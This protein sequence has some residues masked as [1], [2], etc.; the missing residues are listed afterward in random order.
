M[1]KTV[2]KKKVS[3]ASVIKE[4]IL[5]DRSIKQIL[6]SVTKKVPSSKADETHVKYYARQLLNAGTLSKTKASEKYGIGN[7]NRGRKPKD[8]TETKK[9]LRK[10][11][12]AKK[13]PAAKKAPTKTVTKKAPVKKKVAKKSVKG[14]VKKSTTSK[15]KV[16]TK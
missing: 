15:R 16:S 7:S 11:P 6:A 13:A 3:A 12:T 10:K 14:A 5:A 1:T 9:P 8:A 4:G 2:Q